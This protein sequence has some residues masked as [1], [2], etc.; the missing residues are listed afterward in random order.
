MSSPLT[1]KDRMRAD[2]IAKIKNG[3]Y[4]VGTKLPSGRELCEIYGVS[5]MTVRVVTDYLRTVGYVKGIAGS[6]IWVTSKTANI[7]E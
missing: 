1:K 4:P 5:T 3:T 2:L 7:G 6:G